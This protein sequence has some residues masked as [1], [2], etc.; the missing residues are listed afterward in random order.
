MSE[1]TPA[2]FSLYT[3]LL[4]FQQVQCGV[5]DI[6]QAIGRPEQG[7]SEEEHFEQAAMHLIKAG[8]SSGTS[9]TAGWRCPSCSLEQ[10]SHS[11]KE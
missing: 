10:P 9:E 3:H 5:C 11:V 7:V 4:F 8:W 2:L 1:M 6:E